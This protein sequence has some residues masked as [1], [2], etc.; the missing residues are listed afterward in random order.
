[1]NRR[2]KVKDFLKRLGVYTF[3]MKDNPD[4]SENEG[5]FGGC[6]C[7][8]EANIVYRSDSWRETTKE[9]IERDLCF[10]CLYMMVYD[11]EVV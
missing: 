8:G 2:E 5:S 1:M 6:D 7:C 9:I 3:T 11:E 4:G 10:E